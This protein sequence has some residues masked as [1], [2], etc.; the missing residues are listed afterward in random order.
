MR[1]L[2]D[3]RKSRDLSQAEM[4]KMLGYTLSMYEKVESGRAGVS[5]NFLLSFKRVFP[6]ANIDYIFFGTNSK[7]VA[8]IH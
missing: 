6:E 5:S 2:R 4:A 3:F 7:D 1:N 8:V